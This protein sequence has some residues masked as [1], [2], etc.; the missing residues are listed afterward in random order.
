MHNVS[1]AK[2]PSV[3]KQMASEPVAKSPIFKPFTGKKPK[4]KSMWD[5]H[6]LSFFGIFRVFL[7]LCGIFNTFFT[8]FGIF[9]F[10]KAY[11]GY[12]GF[13]KSMWNIQ[14]FLGLFGIFRVF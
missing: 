6:G 10:F 13:F 2:L 7:G 1:I 14:G 11:L 3:M 4:G 5:I 9:R 8:L 12:S